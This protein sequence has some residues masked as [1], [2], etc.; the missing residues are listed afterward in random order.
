MGSSPTAG[1][2]NESNTKKTTLIKIIIA[3]LAVAFV[4]F[5]LIYASIR[6]KKN[7]PPAE[8]EEANTPESI[9][10]ENEQIRMLIPSLPDTVSFNG[11]YRSDCEAALADG[12]MIYFKTSAGSSVYINNYRDDKLVREAITVN[13]EEL[14]QYI[15][16]NCSD[17][18]D[19]TVADISL[20]EYDSADAYKEYLKEEYLP[21]EKFKSWI[22]NGFA[23]FD[24]D[25]SRVRKYY[26]E[27][28]E[29]DIEYADMCSQSLKAY[30]ADNGYTTDEFTKEL[31]R[32]S[33]RVICD[34]EMT[35]AVLCDT[36]GDVS[37]DDIKEMAESNGYDST[38][39]F[40]NKN[41]RDSILYYLRPQKLLDYLNKRFKELP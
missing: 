15:N 28:L 8:T 24:V 2:M 22:Y 12:S 25:E 31:I 21:I 3:A 20:G 13:D 37:E 32:S 5:V 16:E 39:E 17:L 14:A 33:Y 27:Q 9:E 23:V 36:V 4:L 34:L 11:L 41:G 38:E 26:S 29:R 19:E 6:D 7:N 1:I 30:L 18:S 40:I 35:E 10:S